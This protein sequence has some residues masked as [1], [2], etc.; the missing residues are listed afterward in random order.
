[1]T[2]R[3]K[4]RE[5]PGG[6]RFISVEATAATRELRDAAV[7]AQTVGSLRPRLAEFDRECIELGYA[8][9]AGRLRLAEEAAHAE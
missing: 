7:A 6:T 3:T 9:R 8:V 5:T 4:Q 2:P 1:M